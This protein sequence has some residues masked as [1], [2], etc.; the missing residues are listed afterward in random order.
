MPR[1]EPVTTATL[2]VRSNGVDCIVDS[3]SSSFPGCASRRDPESTFLRDDSRSK[4][5]IASRDAPGP[6]MTDVPYTNPPC[7][8]TRRRW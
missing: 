3:F 5:W 4:T 8:L 6:R 1:L 2:P 7:S